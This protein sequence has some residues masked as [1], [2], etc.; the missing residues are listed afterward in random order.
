LEIVS[1]STQFDDDEPWATDGDKRSFDVQSVAV[2]EA[3]HW[4]MLHHTSCSGNVMTPYISP[5]EI[6]RSL[7]AG[8]IAGINAIYGSGPTPPLTSGYTV[9][10]N[11]HDS[12]RNPVQGAAVYMDSV[13]QGTT[14]SWGQCS[15]H[16][17]SK[18]KHTFT[19]TKQGYQDASR[20]VN[21]KQDTEVVLVLKG[22]GPS[23]PPIPVGY[24]VIISVFDLS[25]SP[26]SGA[27][28]YIDDAKKGTT[29]SSGKLMITG[30][31]E[32]YHMILVKKRGYQDAYQREYV[33]RDMMLYIRL[34][35]A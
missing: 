29:D 15:I 5:G 9:T 1:A 6:K 21:V 24:T 2:H 35:P 8:D 32:G 20:R 14:D 19:A 34:Y 31:P 7:G 28:V 4:L 23:P 30:I 10:V 11:V 17:V 26:I 27:T 3:G 25:S 16:G 33:N 22:G 18:G 12:K 13:W